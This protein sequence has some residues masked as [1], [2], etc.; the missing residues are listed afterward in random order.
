MSSLFSLTD[1]TAVSCENISYPHTVVTDVTS[2]RFGG[3][4]TFSCVDG[5]ERDSG[6]LVMNCEMNGKWSG[7]PPV[8]KGMYCC[9][10][11]L[12]WCPQKLK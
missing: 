2:L 7:D 5:Y 12:H 9:L 3:S 10:S 8:C 6:I 11:T 4:I 1:L